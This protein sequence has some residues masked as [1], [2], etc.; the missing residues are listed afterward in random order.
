VICTLPIGALTVVPL[1]YSP[2]VNQLFFWVTLCLGAMTFA[3]AAPETG[4]HAKRII[5]VRS[6]L[7]QVSRYQLVLA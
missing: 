6:T 3:R 7:A 2:F 5:S 4:L 1:S